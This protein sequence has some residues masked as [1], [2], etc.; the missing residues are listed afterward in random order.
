MRIIR[1]TERIL[2]VFDISMRCDH[3]YKFCGQTIRYFSAFKN[4]NFLYFNLAYIDM[5]Y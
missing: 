4:T 2:N 1:E 5:K 3:V